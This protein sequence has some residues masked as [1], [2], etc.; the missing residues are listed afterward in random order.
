MA[1]EGHHNG[2]TDE[3]DNLVKRFT[4]ALSGLTPG[5]L[6]EVLQQVL[7]AGT[8]GVDPFERTPPPSRR[9]PRRPDVVTYRVRVDLKG[10]RPPLWRRLELGSDLFLNDVHDVIQ[11]AFG[12]T[13]SHLH[14][15]SAGPE[16]YSPDTERYLCPFDVAEGEP[17]IPEEQVRLDEVLVEVGD[18]L[19]YA[20]DFG[21]DWEHVIR[22]EAVAAREDTAARAVCTAGRRPGPAED[23]GGVHG[24]ELIVAATDP[25]HSDHADAVAE[26][27]RH[28]GDDADPARFSPGT[29]DLSEINDALAGLDTTTSLSQSDLPGPLDELVRAVRTI[30][31]AKRL[32]RLIGDAGL[33]QPVQIDTETAARMVRPYTWLLDRVGTEGITLTGA[34]YLPPAHV[35]AAVTELGLA[36]DWIGKGNRE[37]QT[38]RCWTCANRRRRRGCC[39]NTGASSC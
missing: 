12:W 10:T 25:T 27:A 22:L 8:V 4:G 18:T 36:K 33:G 35:E 7:A 20:Y 24:Y 32:R 16:Y 31:G 14:R 13:D 38:C 28:F 3:A 30:D 26:Y 5:E 34:G 39:A 37:N 9:R 2:I 15:F 1:T 29:F 21:D 11:T 23:C 17:G 19:F 6:Q